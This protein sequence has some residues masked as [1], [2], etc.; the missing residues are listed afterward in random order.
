ML[1]CSPAKIKEY[2]KKY[3]YNFGQL[4]TPLTAYKLSG[5]IYGLDNGCFSNF[6]Q[7]TWRRLIL[8]AKDNPPVFVCAPDI[9]GDARRT[10]ELFDQFYNE[11]HPLPVALVLQDG[12]GN[13]SIDWDRVD[14]V[15]VGGSDNFKTSSE[16]INACKTAKILG[17][18][19][20]VGRV[21]TASRVAQ[22]IGLA[23]SIDGS[24]ISRFDSRLEEVLFEIIGTN[25][26]KD[27]I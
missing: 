2:C 18:W 14:A 3:N 16:A 22:W 26:Q 8:E 21:N 19:V 17:K 6:D 27:L 13:F 5:Q 4:R 25:P 24:G 20:H 23:N 12:I 15:F 11:I 10:L 7:K 9:V 1:D